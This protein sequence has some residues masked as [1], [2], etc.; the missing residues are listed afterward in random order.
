MHAVRPR[1]LPL[2]ACLAL[3]L[4]ACSPPPPAA[5]T[6][7]PAAAPSAADADALAARI[8]AENRAEFAESNSAAWLSQTYIGDDSARV[9]AKANERG[10]TRLNGYLEAARAFTGLQLSD[11]TARTLHLLRLSTSMPA[12]T[13]PAK[14]S[15]LAALA[16]QLDGMYG[17]GSYCSD[18]QNPSTCKQIGELS[19]VLADPDS[20]YAEQLEAWSGWHSIAV[21]MR[22]PYA[23]FAALLNEGA[24]GMGFANAGDMWRS[25]YDMQPDPFKDETDRL[26]SQVQPLYEQLHCYTRGKLEAK[27][28]EQCS[29]GGLLPAH[30]TGNLWQQDWSNLWPILQPY[31]NAGSLDITAA[32]QAQRDAMFKAEVA[33]LG[34]S[35]TPEA[36]VEAGRAADL[37]IATAM[38]RRA[39]EFY[40]N[41]GMPK[42]PDSFW[43]KSQLIKP[44]DRDVVCHASAWDIDLAGDVRIKMCITPTEE[45]FTT[46]YHELGHIYYYLAYNHLPPMFQSGAHDGFHEAIGDT[47]VL[48]LTPDYLASIDLVEAPQQSQEA[49]INA[50]MRQALSKVAFMPFGLMIDRWRWGVFDGSITEANYNSA[51]W[52]L[53]AQYQGVAPATPRGEDFFDPGAKYHVPGNTP[54]TRYFL[55]HILQFQFYKA[56]CDASG[57]TGPLYTC[58]FAGNAEA[59]RRFWAMLQQGQS[60][61]WQQT[62]KEL[63]GGE[64]MDAS[65]VLEYFA[66]LQSWLQ[67]QNQ[68]QSCGWQRG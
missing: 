68:G 13:D 23:R 64:Q 63:T 25:G 49:V 26:W 6:N 67:E 50:Q 37:E 45:E 38:T 61:P 52:N 46:I 24:Q 55:S 53:K 62:L 51:W 40:V 41:L 48:S 28:G 1:L 33:K 57:H 42:L 21:P 8:N 56:L 16:T 60:K 30:L 7:A 47:I 32:L 43:T 36:L 3:G 12:P 31:A 59:G 65:A 5:T 35:P 4:A 9:A 54:Y 27:Y 10:L 44:R 58:S 15:E 34:P 29:V 20:S 2:S 11:A 17:A 39:E 22:A 14:L 19:E 18:P 66:P